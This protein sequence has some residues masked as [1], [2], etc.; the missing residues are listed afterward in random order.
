MNKQ[1]PKIVFTGGHAGTTAAT[2]ASRAFDKGY[3][4]EIHWIGPQKAT[5]GKSHSTL[6]AK[7]FPS[8][9]IKFHSIVTGR[10]QRKFTF[11]TIPSLLRIPWGFAEALYLLL[12]IRP[13]LILSFGGFAA[14]PVVVIGWSLGIPVIVHEQTTAA[15]R[16]NRAS[17]LFAKK[18]LLSREESRIYF[19]ERKCQVVGNPIPEMFFNIDQKSVSTK[20]VIFVTGGSRGSQIINEK[21]RLALPA[22]LSKFKVIH[23]VGEAD[24]DKFEKYKK[25]LSLGIMTEYEIVGFISP[26]KMADYY[27][28]A[29]VVVGRSGANTVAEIIAAGKPTI[30]IPIPWSY[31]NEQ[32]KNAQYAAKFIPVEII[33]QENLNTTNLMKKIDLLLAK[34]EKSAFPKFENPDRSAAST[35]TGII[36][37]YLKK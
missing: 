5:E 14:F 34:A 8:L 4:W 35:I 36:E 30:F 1:N 23:Q 3:G 28:K 11:W 17:A 37:I 24:F 20:P 6:E 22:L 31:L 2:I 13:K 9:G 21:I 25:E 29:D 16:A 7:I 32:S 33:S 27:A 26:S 15:G 18:I 19:P 12:K 10:L